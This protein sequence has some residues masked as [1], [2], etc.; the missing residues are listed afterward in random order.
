MPECQKI[1]TDAERDV[2]LYSTVKSDAF[3]FACPVKCLTGT[4]CGQWR[5]LQS[6][7]WREPHVTVTLVSNPIVCRPSQLIGSSPCLQKGGATTHQSWATTHTDENNRSRGFLPTARPALAIAAVA[8]TDRALIRS[9]AAAARA[10]RLATRDPRL[11]GKRLAMPPVR[12]AM[13]APV[14]TR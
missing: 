5:L 7:M 2:Q 11:P 10:L 4:S 13:M 14:S 9:A 12:A 6:R 8:A 1:R 3:G